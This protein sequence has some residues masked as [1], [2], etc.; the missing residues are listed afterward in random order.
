[1]T[2]RSSERIAEY[3]G[4]VD[5]L[6][7]I[8]IDEKNRVLDGV[9]RFHAH[10]LAGKT[11]IRVNVVKADS[12]REALA[13]AIKYNARHGQRL[14]TDELK[15]S[16]INLFHAGATDAFIAKTI[17][18]SQKTVSNYLREA[19]A[20]LKDEAKTLAVKLREEGC[21]QHQIA[22]SIEDRLNHKV[23]QTTVSAWLREN[24]LAQVVAETQP[25]IVEQIPQKRPESE[26]DVGEI[27]EERDEET[28][29]K[30]SEMQWMLLWLGN[31]LNL[32]LWLP[33]TDLTQ[34]HRKKEIASL[35]GMLA[36]LPFD[37]L[38]A[39]RS[40]QRIDVLWLEDNK[41]IA[42]FEIENS[43]G[44][45]SGLLRMSHMWVSMDDSSIRAHIV[46]QD[47]DV[48]K[49]RDKINAPTF[50]H[51]GLAESCYF[52]PYSAITN[53]Y[54]EAEQNDSIPYDWQEFL[55]VIGHKL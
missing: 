4:N 42:A 48:N 38:K 11:E 46:A 41:I 30:H 29:R 17:S 52:I 51:N 15:H 45:E 23:D 27:H 20:H 21:T 2:E 37:I 49:A 35:S 18:R 50:R 32:D 12:R 7:P 8:L 14:T 13:Y 9:H 19:K 44:I 22:N 26:A 43:T 10:K 47:S 36:N 3:A 53:R 5:N 34:S 24:T 55:D 6:P 40:V 39:G 31:E 25:E 16:A 54:N 28:E 33:R 1:M